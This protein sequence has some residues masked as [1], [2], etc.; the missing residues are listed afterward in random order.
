MKIRAIA[1]IVTSLL[2]CGCPPKGAMLKQQNIQRID[3]GLGVDGTSKILA[4]DEEVDQF[5]LE[6][7]NFLKSEGFE[8]LNSSISWGLQPLTGHTK[9]LGLRYPGTNAIYCY[10]KVSKKELQIKFVEIEKQP[11]SNEYATTANDL[12]VVNETIIALTELAKLKFKGRYVRVSKFER[13]KKP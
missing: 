5:A 3:A 11:Q 4:S 9:N 10:V 7:E 6:I 13:A 1:I 12:L 2:L 8:L